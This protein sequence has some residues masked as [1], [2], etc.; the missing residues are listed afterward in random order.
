MKTPRF[1]WQFVAFVFAVAVGNAVAHLCTSAMPLQVGALIDGFGLSATAAGVFGFFQV[2]SLALGMIFFAPLS[3][4]YRPFAVC[5]TGLLIASVTNGAL[6]LSPANFPLLCLLGLLSGF[7]YCL[8]L[9]AT[10]CAP[11]ASAQADKVYAASSSGGLLLLVA[12]LSMLPLANSYFGQRGIFIGIAV[13]LIVSIPLLWGFRYTPASTATAEPGVEAIKGGT[14]KSGAALLAIWVLYSLGTGAMWTFAERIGHA[15]QIPGPTIGVIL[16][17]SVFMALVGSGLAAF[18]S[19]RLDRATAI[20]IGLIGGGAICLMLALSNGLWMYAVA[21]VLYW[22]ITIFFYVLML[23]TAAAIDPTGRLATL[24]TGCERLAFAFGA[25][26][27]G[28][29]VDFGSFL[30]IGLLAVGTCSILAPLCLPSLSRA[31]KRAHADRHIDA[32]PVP[33]V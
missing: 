7:G 12:L 19:D 13:L 15:L 27:G 8:M 11:A 1:S 29:F 24:G 30:W 14:L 2:G 5:L 25:P 10:V 16:S 32:V 3:H 33:L 23:G 17:V 6:Y 31:L 4:R 18:V 9:S 22:I 26:I 21:C 20:G 28:M